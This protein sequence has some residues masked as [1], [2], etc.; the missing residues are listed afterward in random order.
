MGLFASFQTL[1]GSNFIAKGFSVQPGFAPDDRAKRDLREPRFALNHCR[2]GDI[3]RPYGGF[4]CLPSKRNFA[5]VFALYGEAH[6][7]F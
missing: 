7:G 4:Y 6:N 3:R 1:F 5:L 2:S